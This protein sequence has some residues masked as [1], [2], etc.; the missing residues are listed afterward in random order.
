MPLARAFVLLA[1]SLLPLAGASA[2]GATVEVDS[3]ALVFERATRVEAAMPQSSAYSILQDQRGFLWFSTREGLGRWDGY[4]M[5]TWRRDPFDSA[6]LAGNVVRQMVLDGAGDLWVHTERTDRAPEGV[7]RLIGP[8]HERVQRYGHP[9]ARLFIGPEGRAWLADSTHLRRFSP[10]ADRFEPV[11]ERSTN[12]PATRGLGAS[13]GTIWLT[14]ASGV[15]RYASGARGLGTGEAHLLRAPSLLR[16]ADNEYAFEQALAEDASGRIWAS[17]AGLG[18]VEGDEIIQVDAPAP[19]IQGYGEGLAAGVLLPEPGILWLGT[20]DGVYRY[21]I[22]ADDPAS[23]EWE[24]YSLR[25]PGDIPTQNWVTGLHRDRAGTLWAGTVWGLHRAVPRQSPFRLLAHDPDDPNTIGSGIVLSIEEDASGTL[26]VG[27]LGG[28]LNRIG[29]DGTVTRYRHDPGDPT[30][31][32]HDWIWSVEADADTLWIGT[33][34]GLNALA[35]AAPSRIERIPYPP[36]AREGWGPSAA[37]L[38]LD[39]EG[40]LWYG[41]AG[42]LNRR[43][44]SGALE[45]FALPEPVGVQD[46]KTVPEGAWVS[47]SGGLLFYTAE[48]GAPRRWQHDPSNPASLPDDASIGLH[49]DGSDHLWVGTQSGLARMGAASDTPPHGESPSCD[50]ASGGGGFATLTTDDGL[51]SAAVYEMLEDD[52]G[53]IWVSTNRGLARIDPDAPEALVRAYT[54]ADGVGNVEFNRGAAVRGADGTM[55]FGGD[56][57]VTV[58]HPADLRESPYVPP[59]AITALHR[60]GREGTET[61]RYVGDEEIA[62]APGVTAFTFEFAALGFAAPERYRY[63][64]WLDGWDEGWV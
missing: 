40:A 50:P 38:H 15:E 10:E 3:D 44:A 1:V 21:R 63:A 43:A 2:Q 33:G 60:S 36:E 42:R 29:T 16:P 39:T 49:L 62:L 26:W 45:T 35:L 22:P 25:L 20:L 46:V 51:P 56:R 31:L 34:E 12:D 52:D 30:T 13:D 47:T 11:R 48:G 54:E 18:Y 59:V 64:V 58:F 23:G 9:G 5:R 17:G 57:G 32:A 37:G 41:H 61:Q 7:V 28:G 55:Y 24:R 6:S 8:D 14:S 4:T 27:T 53:R 19:M